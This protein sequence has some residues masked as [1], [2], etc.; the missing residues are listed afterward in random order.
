MVLRRIE[1]QQRL[2]VGQSQERNFLSAQ[3]LLDDDPVPRFAEDAP[4]HDFVDGVVRLGEG[5]ADDH[6]FALG[7]PVRFHHHRSEGL[8]QG[9]MRAVRVVE[10]LERRGGDIMLVQQLLAED[11]AALELGGGLAGAEDFEALGSQF[12]R[13]AHGE[14]VLGADHRQVNLF[15][16]HEANNPHVV[17]HADLDALGVARDARIARRAIEFGEQG[18]LREFP[19]Q[20]VLAPTAA[21]DEDFHSVLPRMLASEMAL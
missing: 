9:F 7:Q 8:L 19:S 3:A 21:D 15:F 17:L 20:R 18:G 2:A 16:P 1:Q 5:G 4:L 12:I 14:G 10:D 6:P 13:Q 11:L